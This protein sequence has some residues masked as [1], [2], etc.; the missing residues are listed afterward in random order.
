MGIKLQQL[1]IFLGL[2]QV[3]AVPGHHEENRP[4]NPESDC[5][6]PL[7]RT[8]RPLSGQTGGKAG[9]L[10]IGHH[11]RA[12]LPECLVGVSKWFASRETKR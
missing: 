11:R 3:Y 10:R 5:W 8:R 2:R 12:L 7:V 4:R 9:T 1:G 6:R